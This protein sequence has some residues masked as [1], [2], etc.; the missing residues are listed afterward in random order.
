MVFNARGRHWSAS[1]NPDM[2]L[3]MNQLTL[4][5]EVLLISFLFCVHENPEMLHSDNAP[6]DDEDIWQYVS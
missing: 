6:K 2:K 5:P 3:L 4:L 1:S